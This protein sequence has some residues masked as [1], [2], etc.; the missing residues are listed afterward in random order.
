MA[1]VT[2]RSLEQQVNESLSQERLVA[3]IA[4]VFGGLA[5]LLAGLGLY[6]VAA[7]S[8]S[9]RRAE[10][11]I[12]MALGATPG[13]IVRLVLVRIGWMVGIGLACGVAMSVWAG[14]FVDSMLY[15]LQP[16]DTAT[17]VTAAMTLAI[18]ALLAG[19][20][21]ARRASRID[22]TIVLREG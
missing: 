10:I 15:G 13:G 3:G 19:G 17:L 8:V 4:A 16:H 18:V 12:R 20:L 21:P 22:P 7:Y 14:K 2:F 1:S 6:G 11:G 9:R 5:L